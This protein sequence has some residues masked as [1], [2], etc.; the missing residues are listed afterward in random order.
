M[1][2]TLIPTFTAGKNEPKISYGLPFYEACRKHV[3]NTF[4]ASRI[5]IISS[6]S[7]AKNTE[8]LAHL[9]SAL[10]DRVAGTRIGMRPHTQWGDIL[11]IVQEA[12]NVKADL[13]ITLG[14]GSLTDGAKIIALVK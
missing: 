5:Y 6:A 3:Q 12:Q 14:A 11:E 13:L 8:A 2:E 4:Q 9:Q 1:S 7:L 10:G